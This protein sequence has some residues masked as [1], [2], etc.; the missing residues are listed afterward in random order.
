MLTALWKQT[1]TKS[2]CFCA[3]VVADLG[4]SVPSKLLSIVGKILLHEPE[5]PGH[6]PKVLWSTVW[7]GLAFRDQVFLSLSCMSSSAT[8]EQVYLSQPTIL[9][10]LDSREQVSQ[11]TGKEWIGLARD[12]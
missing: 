12:H 10:D 4:S 3:V 8:E 9:V 6:E 7:V 5:A 1:E 2:E 11:Y